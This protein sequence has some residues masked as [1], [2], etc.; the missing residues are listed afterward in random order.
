M[1]PPG[2][3]HL[4]LSRYLYCQACPVSQC[5]FA[6]PEGTSKKHW[7]AWQGWRY[8]YRDKG[9]WTPP[10]WGG[11]K[12][13]SALGD[14]SPFKR[15]VIWKDLSEVY[16]ERFLDR[17]PQYISC[18][19]VP[20]YICIVWFRQA[21]YRVC[22]ATDSHP[23]I[24]ERLQG[25]SSAFHHGCVSQPELRTYVKKFRKK[26]KDDLATQR[27]D[28]KRSLLRAWKMKHW[29]YGDVYFV[30]VNYIRLRG[31]RPLRSSRWDDELIWLNHLTYIFSVYYTYLQDL[32]YAW[33][34]Q[35]L[36]HMHE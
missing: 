8:Q 4:P 11:H 17:S 34:L 35:H 25:R 2:G 23:R 31:L 14:V 7:D 3:G 26:E 9:R 19:V 32:I 5:F 36:I 27:V 10:H 30:S 12:A 1:T 28:M 13:L 24:A 6:G 33:I 29:I 20:I 21:S 18:F 15:G 16:V 22:Q